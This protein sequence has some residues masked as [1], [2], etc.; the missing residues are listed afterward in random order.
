MKGFRRKQSMFV[1]E[2]DDVEKRILRGIF[3]DT[4]QLLGTDLRAEDPDEPGD[5]APAAS[6]EEVLRDLTEEVGEPLDP[7]LARLLPRAYEDDDAASEFRRLTE[8][9]IRTIKVDRLRAW[10]S[11]LRAPGVNLYVPVEEAG[12]WVAAITDVRLVLA[13][14]LGVE[15]DS[16]AEEV[17]ARTAPSGASEEDYTQFALGQI[18]SALTWLQESLLGAMMSGR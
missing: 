3:A 13:T 14:R 10:V 1:A 9:D 5:D 11:A 6:V 17:Y 8:N 4:A 15:S 7:A 12:E 18:Y 2:V 16:D